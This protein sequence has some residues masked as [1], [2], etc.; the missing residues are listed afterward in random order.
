[1]SRGIAEGTLVP[2]ARIR[3]SLEAQNIQHRQQEPDA[4]VKRRRMPCA[5]RPRER[6]DR[7]NEGR[8]MEYSR[9][10]RKLGKD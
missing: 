3:N 10:R 7:Y 8:R 5:A 2:Q 4:D 6:L 9:S 1:L